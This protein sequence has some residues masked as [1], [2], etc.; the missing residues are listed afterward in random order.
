MVSKE[1]LRKRLLATFK[2]EAAEHLHVLT[3]ELDAVVAAPQAASS[4]SRLEILFRVMHT[5]KGASRSVQLAAIERICQEC[6]VELRAVTRGETPVTQSFI[7]RLVDA[8]DKLRGLIESGNDIAPPAEPVGVAAPIPAA[9]AAGNGAAT[10][11]GSH[12]PAERPRAEP[13]RPAAPALENGAAAREH[14]IAQAAM[15]GTVRVDIGRLDRLLLAAEDLLLPSLAAGERVKA[16]RQMTQD[17]TALRTNL[18]AASRS[19]SGAANGHRPAAEVLTAVRELEGRSRRLAAS[20]ADDQRALRAAVGDLFQETRHARMIPAASMLAAF[21]TMVRDLC[22]STGKEAAWSLHDIGLDLDRKVIEAIKAP[23]IHLVRNAIDHGIERPDER[24]AAG[25]PRRGSVTVSIA[26][27]DNGRIAIEIKDDGR[28]MDLTALRDAAVRSRA[29]SAAQVKAMSDDDVIDIAF[30]AGVSTSAVI[31][32]ISGLGL[33]LAIVREQIERIDGHVSVHS[34][35]GK[36]TTFRLE[37]PATVASYRGLLVSVQGAR[38]LWPAESVIRAIGVPK[39]AFGAALQSGMMVHGADTLPFGRLG[40]IMGI[41]LTDQNRTERVLVPCILGGNA[42]R[43]AIFAVDEILGETE[44]LIKD[45]PSPLRRV[46]N[47]SS[48]GLLATGELAL[49]LRPSDLLTSVQV[50]QREESLPTN[51]AA[52]AMRVLV[53]DD[54]ITTRTMERN[55]LEAAGYDVSTAADGL[56]AWSM[57]QAEDIDIVVS[58]V[59]MPRMNGF[60]LTSRIRGDTRLS[61]LP[62]VLVTALES[63]DDKERGIK[64]GANAYVLKSSFEQSNLLEIVGRLI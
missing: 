47:V 1:E 46:R 8:T 64:I 51:A 31:T 15:T 40:S 38:L 4:L 3:E 29:A 50:A 23:L 59:D 41:P 53:V 6:E 19:R 35:Q 44:V 45:F 60:D 32:S 11:N 27:T 57:L 36:G 12:P 5:L 58:D 42:Q 16:A 13:P 18:R 62:I 28:G 7:D 21:P 30:R 37:I 49:V 55:L 39:A 34:V 14:D 9:K 24:V 63:R 43:R 10:T 56:D 2:E 52:R 26:A 33:G 22:R 20:L 54:S 61:E 17:V 25:K 48:V